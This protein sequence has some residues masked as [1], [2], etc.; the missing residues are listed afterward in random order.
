MPL[1]AIASAGCIDAR[2]EHYGS[3]RYYELTMTQSCRICCPQNVWWMSHDK[4]RAAVPYQSDFTSAT[5]RWLA[6]AP[7]L[8]ECWC[9]K[10]KGGLLFIE[11][12]WRGKPLA[13][14]PVY[15]I[16]CIDRCTH[17]TLDPIHSAFVSLIIPWHP[18]CSSCEWDSSRRTCSRAPSTDI[19]PFVCIQS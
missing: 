15:V 19:I 4:R 6:V 11:D 12:R 16:C 9:H 5:D 18:T 14:K 7:L 1:A 8:L 13:G 3:G 2:Y 17:R 10:K